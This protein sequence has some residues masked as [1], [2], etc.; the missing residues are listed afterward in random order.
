MTVFELLEAIADARTDFETGWL[1]M[2]ARR[3]DSG[4]TAI[5][6]PDWTVPA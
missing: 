4:G 3:A 6:W 1:G 2:L 5:D